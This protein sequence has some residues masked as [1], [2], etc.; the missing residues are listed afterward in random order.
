MR[1][2]LF[3]G[4]MV[5]CCVNRTLAQ[6]VENSS[7]WHGT[8]GVGPVFFPKYAGS[9]DLEALPLPIAYVDYDDWFYINLFRA[10]AYV[11]SSQDKKK[12]IS[13]A[14]EPRIGFKSSSG[15][16]LAGM[17]T[18]RSGLQG[19]P[20]FDWEGDL[21]SLSVGYFTDLS[22][23]SHGGY[24]DALFN[25]LLVKNERWNVNGSLEISRMNSKIEN[26]YFGV[27]PAE[28]TPVRPLYQPGASTAVTFWL[29]GQ[30][31][32]TKQYALMLGANVTQLG[33]AAA[34]S[35]IVERRQ[36]PL[37]YMGLGW[38]L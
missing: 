32:L 30:Y 37:F 35:P 36:V 18:R 23:A 28:V 5:L 17:E 1:F 2:F 6:T 11:W 25:K 12:A 9:K 38:I 31:N 16:K 24:L 19:G 10:G 34:N 29:T 13:F 26:Y 22:G 7:G 14:M 15:P 20:T 33:G 3:A 27:R 21:G 4:L 8:V